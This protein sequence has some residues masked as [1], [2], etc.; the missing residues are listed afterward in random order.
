MCLVLGTNFSSRRVPNDQ[1]WQ[2]LLLAQAEHEIS[3]PQTAAAQHQQHVQAHASVMKPQ[4]AN[5]ATAFNNIF[6]QV[7]YD[8]LDLV[9]PRP[10][11]QPSAKSGKVY[12]RCG[13]SLGNGCGKE[14]AEYLDQ[15]Y[16]KAFKGMCAACVKQLTSSKFYTKEA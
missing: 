8:D 5:T 12:E 6:K 15:H 2:A 10:A 4:Y 3:P 9:P 11:A 7:Y 13:A 1:A 16:N 14:L